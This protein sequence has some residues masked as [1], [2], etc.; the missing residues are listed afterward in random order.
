MRG[1]MKMKEFITENLVTIIIITVVVFLIL[2]AT[3]LKKYLHGEDI[4]K[5]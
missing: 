2:G 1:A 3:P 5:A 4:V